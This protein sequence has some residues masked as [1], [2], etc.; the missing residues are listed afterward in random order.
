MGP[1]PTGKSAETFSKMVNGHAQVL[2]TIYPLRVRSEATKNM[3]WLHVCLAMAI[4]V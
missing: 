2:A 3:T 4:F 1:E